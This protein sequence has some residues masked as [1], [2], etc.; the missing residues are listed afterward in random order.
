VRA[1]R[2][3]RSERKIDAG[4]WLE[5]YV[6]AGPALAKHAPAIEQLARVR[7]LYIVAGR[8]GAPSDSVATAVLDG[9]T[10]ILPVA[11]LF[12]ST[13]ERANLEKQRD[14]A[15]KL[16]DDLEKKLSSDFATKA[17]PNIVA[18]ERERLEAAKKRLADIEARL[19]ELG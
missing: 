6:V 14:Q 19:K 1:V 7:P 11:G 15:K 13:A 10:V 5:A 17:P 9:A 12:D 3:L 16:A 18:G 4:R 2:N 8:D